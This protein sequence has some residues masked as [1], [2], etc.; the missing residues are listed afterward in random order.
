MYEIRAF[1]THANE[2][3]KDGKHNGKQLYIF[4]NISENVLFTTR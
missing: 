2:I 1:K 4:P 3:M